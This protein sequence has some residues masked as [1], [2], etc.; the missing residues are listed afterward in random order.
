MPTAPVSQRK[1]SNFPPLLSEFLIKKLQNR[2]DAR[3][4]ERISYQLKNSG[5]DPR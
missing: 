3:I 2:K 4:A 1:F 5:K